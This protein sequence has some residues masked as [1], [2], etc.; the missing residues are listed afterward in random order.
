MSNDFWDRRTIQKARK[1]HRCYET[2]A[3]IEPGQPYV[4]LCGKHEGDFYSYKMHPEIAPI[5]ERRNSACWKRDKEGLIFGDLDSD[6]AESLHAMPPDPQDLADAET[7]VRLWN[8]NGAEHY[9][10]KRLQEIRTNQDR[11]NQEPA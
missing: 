10:S 3:V 2:R 6:I 9:L 8:G 1:V 5:W 4:V 7:F 11:A